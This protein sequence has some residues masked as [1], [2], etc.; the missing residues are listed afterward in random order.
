M[1]GTDSVAAV[2]EMFDGM[3]VVGQQRFDDD[4]LVMGGV[5]EIAG[6]TESLASQIERDIRAIGIESLPEWMRESNRV[7]SIMAV[8]AREGWSAQQTWRELGKTKEFKKR[9]GTAFE[10]MAEALRTDDP[11]TVATEI[12]QREE[13]IRESY[14]TYRGT[15]EVSVRYMQKLMATGWSVAE[16]DSLLSAEKQLRESPGA[17]ENFNAI[18]AHLGREAI[19][20]QQLAQV[21]AGVASS[22]VMES[23][24]DALRQSALAE[25]GVEISAAFAAS[26][27]DG[28]G[29]LEQP[30]YLAAVAQQAAQHILRFRLE[31]DAGKFGLTQEDIL[32][33]AFD[34]ER[35]SEV[36]EVLAKFARER[37]AA[38]AGEGGPQG[39]VD[40]AGNL[41]VQGL[42]GL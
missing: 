22:E 28:S 5:D 17:L 37:S 14:W 15:R 26:L 9:F 13:A 12:L 32:S 19:S 21:M 42:Q 24:N 7:V 23:V 35:S 27:G 25:Q 4:Y 1:F 11:L 18:Q 6:S 33:A 34:D 3:D 30:E 2:A 40:A 16:I 29:A 41:R 8:G 38:S 36:D 31:L 20:G 10:S 39:Y